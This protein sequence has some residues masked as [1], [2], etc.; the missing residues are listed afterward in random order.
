MAYNRGQIGKYFPFERIRFDTTKHP[1]RNYKQGQPMPKGFGKRDKRVFTSV[2]HPEKL[3]LE[4]LANTFGC[5]ESEALRICLTEM[6]R[7]IKEGKISRLKDSPKI[8]QSE[9][10]NEWLREARAADKAPRPEVTRPAIKASQ[11]ALD[12][13]LDNAE[14]RYVER[15]VYMNQLKYEG[16]LNTFVD[17]F[18]ELDT[19]AIDYHQQRRSEADEAEYLDSLSDKDRKTYVIDGLILEGW[20]PKDAHQFWDESQGE[21][22]TNKEFQD[23]LEQLISDNPDAD[24]LELLDSMEEDI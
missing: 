9:V 2:C 4:G 24:L 15:G 19:A 5:S 23:N 7:H 13:A 16:I 10:A 20:T 18:G 11:K 8:S 17:A 1:S 22:Q 21:A 3:V 6:G 12:D 14:E